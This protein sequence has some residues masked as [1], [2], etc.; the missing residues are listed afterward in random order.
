RLFGPIAALIGLV[1]PGA[2][3]LVTYLFKRSVLDR[4]ARTETVVRRIEAGDFSLAAD[5]KGSDEIA[6]L[7]Q[8]LNV[9]ARAVGADRAML[10]AAVRQRTEQLERIAYVDQLSGVLNRRGFVEA[11]AQ[12]ERRMA[13]NA[14]R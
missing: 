12:E 1:R 6:R 2:A 7:A 11:F 9:M 14:P 8:T 13:I 4:L 10:E 5:E 3:A